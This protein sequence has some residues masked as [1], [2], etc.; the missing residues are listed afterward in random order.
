MLYSD[1]YKLCEK[2]GYELIPVEENTT[3]RV[4]HVFN[5]NKAGND[6]VLR[7]GENRIMPSRLITLRFVD[8]DIGNPE[9]RTAQCPLEDVNTYLTFALRVD[10]RVRFRPHYLRHLREL[11]D[12]T[13]NLDVTIEESPSTLRLS[14]HSGRSVLVT[15]ADGFT[16]AST[17]VL[18]TEGGGT[19][20]VFSDSDSETFLTLYRLVENWWRVF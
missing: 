14:D 11:I 1:T 6:L 13:H 3:E 9:A 19:Y 4:Y 8:V 17:K 20:C 5:N 10:G 2:Y 16:D 7:I 18:I 12:A 15:F